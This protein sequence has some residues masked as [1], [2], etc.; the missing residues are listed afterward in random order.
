[1]RRLAWSLAF[2]W[3]ATE[4]AAQGLW[5]QVGTT[6]VGN[7]VYVHVRSVTTARDGIITA[8]VRAVFVKPVKT[9][10]GA[11]TTSR[12]IAMFNCAKQVVAVKESWLFFDEAAN[13]VYEH[14]KPGLPGYATVIGGSLPAV[15]LKY[16]CPVKSSS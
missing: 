6:N 4:A 10:A 14:R 16:F 5:K 8:T 9:A 12:T 11:I 2:V 15:A 1:M 13:R 7:P 3:V